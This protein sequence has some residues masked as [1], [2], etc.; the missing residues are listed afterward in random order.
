MSI[1]G[2]G[3]SLTLAQGHLD[4]KIKTY[5]SQKPLGYL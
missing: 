2:Q 1:Q 5:F 3:H 4:M